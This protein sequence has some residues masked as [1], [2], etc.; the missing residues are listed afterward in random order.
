MGS[1]NGAY[2]QYS[3]IGTLDGSSSGL[4][5]GEYTV[6]ASNVAYPDNSYLAAPGP[7][8]QQQQPL[9]PS[10]QKQEA[11][12]MDGSSW[13]DSLQAGLP[14]PSPSQEVYGYEY[15]PSFQT[16]MPLGQQPFHA[17][18][19][20]LPP[21]AHTPP[22]Q[23]LRVLPP[24]G[25]PR[26]QPSPSKPKT[27]VPRPP[28]AWILY[29]SDK[30]ARAKAGEEIVDISGKGKSGRGIPQSELSKTISKLWKAEPQEKKDYWEKLA[31]EKK[32]EVGGHRGDA[33]SSTRRSTPTTSFNQSA[34]KRSRRRR[35]RES[36]SGR[37][38]SA[39]RTRGACIGA[40][41]GA[42]E[43]A[44]RPARATTTRTISAWRDRPRTLGRLPTRQSTVQGSIVS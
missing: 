33:N 11:L 27:K 25:A 40:R 14:Y 34:R 10:Y 43:V 23:P 17:S 7:S 26:P 42:T 31:Q 5:G 15:D 3:S 38:R 4:Q 18:S 22:Q 13:G 19:S 1:A 2:P 12:A 21:S 36:S 44:P 9:Y 8:Q 28:N 35:R 30:F 29:R 24:T 41:H 6:A 37:T 20:V 16:P 39:A 32:L